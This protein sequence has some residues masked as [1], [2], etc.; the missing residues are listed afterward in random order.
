MV[1]DISFISNNNILLYLGFII[2]SLFV[3]ILGLLGYFTEEGGSPIHT[4]EYTM[5]KF[6]GE[7]CAHDFTVIE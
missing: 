2:S 7:Q 6:H 4:R 1:A 3:T 5:R